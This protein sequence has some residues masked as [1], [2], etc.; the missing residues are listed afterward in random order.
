MNFL[1]GILCS[2]SVEVQLLTVLVAFQITLQEGLPL[3][4]A[5]FRERLKNFK[6]SEQPLEA[7][8]IWA[9]PSESKVQV[10]KETPCCRLQQNSIMFPSYSFMITEWYGHVNKLLAFKQYE[11]G[12][13]HWYEYL[14]LWSRFSMIYMFFCWKNSYS[15]FTVKTFLASL[16]ITNYFQIFLVTF[17]SGPACS[18]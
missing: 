6:S 14:K 11:E 3:M 18:S 5:D 7:W 4:A 2:G 13:W 1:Q 9:S 10:S 17:A 12:M 16:K 15:Q 8:T